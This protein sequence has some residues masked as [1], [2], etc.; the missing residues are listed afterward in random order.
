M[1]LSIHPIP[2]L[3]DN[4]AWLLKDSDS[5]AMAIVD[6]AEEA[7]VMAAI[8]AEA[9]TGGRLAL[10]L[11]TH[12]HA[13]HVAAADAVRARTGAWV[14]GA[15]ADRHR[16]PRLDQAVREGDVV[17]LGN[18]SAEVIETP[19][20]T[21]G[22]ISFFFPQTPALFC[23]DT[24]FSLGCGRLLEGSA[25]E[26]H[27]SL[28]RIG[29]LP[30]DTLICCGHEYTQANAKFALAALP[31]NQALAAQAQRVEQHRAKGLP[32][33]PMRLGDERRANPFLLARDLEEFTRLRSWKDGFR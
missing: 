3:S 7:P 14:V 21:R 4:Y 18:A 11:L 2:I 31:H 33:V 8:E 17:T 28:A 32:T 30:D 16:L 26:M 25:Q 1:T 13:D 24:L 23:G 19:G 6:P 20:H 9:G 5:G 15:A 27:E 29:G 10:I 12:H 22:H